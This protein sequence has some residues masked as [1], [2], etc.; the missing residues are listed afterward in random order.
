MHLKA[1]GVWV[2][3]ILEGMLQSNAQ[4]AQILAQADIPS[5]TDVTGFGLAGHLAE[6]LQ[7]CWSGLCFLVSTRGMRKNC[8]SLRQMGVC[9]CGN[10]KNQQRSTKFAGSRTAENVPEARG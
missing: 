9:W 3:Q 7:F 1:K 10:K 2:D 5:V 6:M 4:A 8:R